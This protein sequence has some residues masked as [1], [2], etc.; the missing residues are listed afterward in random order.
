MNLTKAVEEKRKRPSPIP[1]LGYEIHTP[2]MHEYDCRYP[3]ADKVDCGECVVNG[4]DMD[5]R[6]G[7]KV[8]KLRLLKRALRLRFAQIIEA[9]IG[10]SGFWEAVEEVDGDQDAAKAYA[11]KVAARLRR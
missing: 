9:D 4:G 11:E 3:H 2:D 5:P 6:T 10:R 1:C 7:R 8:D